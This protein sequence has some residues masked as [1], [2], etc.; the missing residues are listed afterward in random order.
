MNVWPPPTIVKQL[1]E[2]LP[3]KQ[4]LR[5]YILVLRLV[6]NS[7]VRDHLPLKQ[8]LRQVVSCLHGEVLL[9]AQRPSSTKTRIKTSTKNGVG[10][11]VFRQRPSSTKTRIET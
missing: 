10:T 1:R 7:H 8:G 4:G 9:L 11:E 6:S 3:L 5:L 2:Y